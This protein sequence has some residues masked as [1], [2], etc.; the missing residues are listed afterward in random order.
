MLVEGTVLYS[1]SHYEKKKSI[2]SSS[3]KSSVLISFSGSQ[4]LLTVSLD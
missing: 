3:Q 2:V 1:K 4:T